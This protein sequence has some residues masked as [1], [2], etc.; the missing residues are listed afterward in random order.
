MADDKVTTQA[1]PHDGRKGAPDGVNTQA[2]FGA[3]GGSDA[4]A[5]YPNP[6]TGTDKPGKRHKLADGPMSHGG[7]SD[8]AY[9][10]S[11]QLG[12]RKVK[13]GGNA[14]SAAREE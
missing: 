14:N 9:H 13:P 7:Q 12:E 4:A 10:G 1:M 3:T 2:E 11:G 6:H 5:P 8:I